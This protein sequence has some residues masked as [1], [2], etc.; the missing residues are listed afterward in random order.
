MSF[1]IVALT[2]LLAS[3]LTFFSGFGLGTILL[4]VF[5]LFFSLPVAIALTA[6]VHLLNNLFKLVL[7]GKHI[8]RKL[9]IR[10]GIPS[11]IAAF[12]GAFVLK[13]L[14]R[15]VVLHTYFINGK[16][17]NITLINVILALVM[18]FFAL[19]ELIPFFKKLSFEKDKIIWGGLLSG[20]F[21]G[22]SGHQGALRSAFLIKYNLAKE[23]FIATGVAIACVVDVV[24]L[25]IYGISIRAV[26][27]TDNALLL[28]L[29]VLSAF[30]GAYFGSKLLKK[31]TLAF[32]QGFVSVFLILIAVL[33]GAGILSS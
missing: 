12:A 3:L 2:A 23:S 14:A 32:V 31:T 27:I 10:F 18:L 5:A 19:Y 26:N 30:I 7:V 11:M 22:F 21:G 16:E 17:F 13:Y 29:A 9:F 20:F 6:I 33:M 4:P 8:D 15:P 1:F 28:S 24:R 25:L